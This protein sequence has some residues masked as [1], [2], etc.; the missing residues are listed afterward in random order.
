MQNFGLGGALADEIVDKDDVVVN[1]AVGTKTGNVVEGERDDS[2]SEG[3][4]C[5]EGSAVCVSTV[6]V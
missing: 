3:G 1:T 2:S 6:K 4:V 5:D